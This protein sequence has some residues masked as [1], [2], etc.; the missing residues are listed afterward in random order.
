MFFGHTQ[1]ANE[2]FNS[3]IWRLSPKHLHSGV[4]IVELSSYLAVGLFNEGNS[5]LLMVMNEA[6][7]TVELGRNKLLYHSSS[8]PYTPPQTVL[9]TP[10]NCRRN[11]LCRSQIEFREYLVP[12]RNNHV[13][14]LNIPPVQYRLRERSLIAVT[15]NVRETGFAPKFHSG[16]RAL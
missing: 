11:K 4:K 12:K 15:I 7:N 8:F 3:T 9:K 13:P 5:S 6:G 1:N 14:L 16:N 2:S 10:G